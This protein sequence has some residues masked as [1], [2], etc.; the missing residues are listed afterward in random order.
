MILTGEENDEREGDAKERE[1]RENER[2]APT[3]QQQRQ[4]QIGDQRAD[5]D[6]AEQAP[7]AVDVL[8]DE[9]LL[10]HQVDLVG[11]REQM[12]AARYQRKRGERER[13]ELN[14]L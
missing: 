7:A 8:H 5:Q 4:R 10:R 12:R 6:N 1:Q 2:R 14:D 13:K 9:I 11:E 3:A